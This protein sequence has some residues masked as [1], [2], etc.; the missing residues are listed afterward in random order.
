[1]NKQKHDAVLGFGGH[2]DD[3]N[4]RY[5][6]NLIPRKRYRARHQKMYDALTKEYSQ[7]SLNVKEFSKEERESIKTRIRRTIKREEMLAT[8]KTVVVTIII[9]LVVFLLFYQNAKGQGVVSEENQWNVLYEEFTSFYENTIEHTLNGDS[10]FNSH[11]YKKMWNY[12]HLTYETFF[13]GLLREDSNRVYYLLPGEDEE[14]ML[15][16]FN[17]ETGDT[18]YIVNALGDYSPFP[19]YITN[20][21][22][23]EYFGVERT[24]WFL[25]DE[26]GNEDIWLEGIGSIY[27]PVHGMMPRIPPYEAYNLL[28]FFQ[29]DMLLYKREGYSNCVVT[30]TALDEST[31]NHGIQI[32]PNPARGTFRIKSTSLLIEKVELYDLTGR[33]L[34]EQKTE[35]CINECEVD[36]SGIK[37]GTYFCRF[38]LNDFA[39]TQKLIIR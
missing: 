39:V 15:Y 28:C 24:R 5:R 23:V 36:V 21:D 1:M 17:A 10:S 20:I 2:A 16:D 32:F 30:H 3:M 18:C 11:D 4:V 34:L 7:R 25:E 22:M 8:V 14:G 6:N 35:S 13:G 31:L 19:V 27:G 29:A 26:Y 38:S 37:P 9:A 12:I 33:K